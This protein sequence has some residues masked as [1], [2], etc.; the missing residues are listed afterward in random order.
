MR[1]LW[2]GLRGSECAVPARLSKR[3][4]ESAITR[5]KLL[6]TRLLQYPERISGFPGRVLRRGRR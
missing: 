1:R 4:R 5:Q 6:Q 3:P 2:Y